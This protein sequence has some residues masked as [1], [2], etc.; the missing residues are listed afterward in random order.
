MRLPTRK[1]E[2][3]N[4]QLKGDDGPVILTR[5][6]FEK[7]KHQ[8]VDLEIQHKQAV[9]D[10]QVT[11]EFGDFS[12]NAEYQE[13]KHRM[14]SLASRIMILKERSKNAAVIQKDEANADRVQ[15]GSSVVV[16]T[17]GIR[18]TFE[19][20]GP[21]ETNPMRGRLSYISPLGI[22]LIGK[23]AG[24]HMTIKSPEGEIEY[25]IIDVK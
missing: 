14:R 15:L 1:K 10:T 22:Q 6:G 12:E 11:G 8:I 2:L 21:Q 7:I 17:N 25:K 4:N 13:A 3:D 19:M 18:R 24:D 5:A 23:R 16:E 20:V 9:K